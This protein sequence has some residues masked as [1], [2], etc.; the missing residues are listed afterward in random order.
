MFIIEPLYWMF[1]TE[2]FKEHFL[3]LLKF[4]FI[5]YLLAFL[6]QFFLMNYIGLDKLV[7]HV[8]LQVVSFILFVSPCLLLSGYFWCL[9][10]N[11]I[12]R[13]QVAR[14]NDVYDGHVDFA[15]KIKLPDLDVGRF[16][17]RGISALVATIIMCLP[18]AFL[19]YLFVTNFDAILQFWQLDYAYSAF[20]GVVIFVVLGSIVPA[21]LW[22]YARRDSVFAPLNIFKASY[23]ISSYPL[24]YFTNVFLFIIYTALQ[25]YIVSVLFGVLGIS[26]IISGLS[27]SVFSSS[28]SGAIF[29]VST[30]ILIV[31]TYII[32]IYWSFVISYLL[33]T[34]APP[35]EY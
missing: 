32:N 16:I 13:E 23:I 19:V 2:N 10:D 34:I 29:G 18:L 15:N 26:T 28:L 7:L 30:I 14:A 35:S 12:D 17:W 1:K 24:K 31:L 11:I 22:N 21:L 4:G 9:T 6:I 27:L 20:I 8:V 25:A 3:F 5:S 33:G